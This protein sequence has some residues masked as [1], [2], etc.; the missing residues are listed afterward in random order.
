MER[1]G[2]IL[3]KARTD[4]GITIRQMAQKL[5]ISAMYISEI[6]TSKKIPLR[7]EK[8]PQ[9]AVYLGLN[10]AEMINLAF[11]EKA[12]EKT[13]EI[14]DDLSLA[15]ARKA[16]AIKDPDFLKR[17]ETFIDTEWNTK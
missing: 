3:C 15:V 14:E 5:G 13:A 6:E 7:G 10:P 17:L 1:L 4:R 9:I 12:T 16:M 8:L 2:Y 11:Q